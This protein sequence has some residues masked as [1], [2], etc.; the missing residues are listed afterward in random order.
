V[1]GYRLIRQPSRSN[2]RQFVWAALLQARAATAG[3]DLVEAIGRVALVLAAVEALHP[4]AKRWPAWTDL[5]RSWW[6]MHT[7]AST[8]SP[9]SVQGHLLASTLAAIHALE[10]ALTMADDDEAT[11][12]SMERTGGL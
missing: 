8:L 12:A 3:D 6:A 5:D 7:A 11:L 9:R 2:D 1:S 10:A 4:D